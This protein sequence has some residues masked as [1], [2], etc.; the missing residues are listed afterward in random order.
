MNAS[1]R[2]WGFLCSV[3][4]EHVVSTFP[5]THAL[6]DSDLDQSVRAAVTPDVIVRTALGNGSVG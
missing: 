3:L 4:M 2:W 1:N 5:D 6:R